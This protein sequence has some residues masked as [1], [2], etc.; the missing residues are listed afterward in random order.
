M[1]SKRSDNHNRR[2][3]ILLFLFCFV[4]LLFAFCCFCFVL[5]AFLLHFAV[6]VFVSF[7][8]F[9]FYCA[10]R[11]SDDILQRSH[12]S[13]RVFVLPNTVETANPV[14]SALPTIPLECSAQ[15][16]CCFFFN[17]FYF[18]YFSLLRGFTFHPDTLHHLGGKVAAIKALT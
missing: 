18:V 17:F 15:W 1:N 13:R 4:S 12:T 3:F 2:R 9:L 5:F 7:C 10:Q 16:F 11:S 8:F 6:F 14:V